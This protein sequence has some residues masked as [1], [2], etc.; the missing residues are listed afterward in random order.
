MLKTT[1]QY[2]KYMQNVNFKHS[3]TNFEYIFAV[4][5][6]YEKYAI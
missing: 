3:L 5:S 4:E 2:I 6:F 1:L